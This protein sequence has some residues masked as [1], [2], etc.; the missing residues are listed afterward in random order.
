MGLFK[1]RRTRIG[2]K[3]YLGYA[4]TVAKIDKNKP[5]VVAAAVHPAHDGHHAANVAFA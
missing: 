4:C 2:M 5:P 1:G 3:G